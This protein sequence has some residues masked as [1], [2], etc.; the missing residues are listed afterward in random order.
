MYSREK[1]LC[2][3]CRVNILRITRRKNEFYT[4]DRRKDVPN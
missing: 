2:N 1:D 3:K 4:Q